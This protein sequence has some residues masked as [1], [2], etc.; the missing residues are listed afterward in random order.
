[1]ALNEDSSIEAGL[2]GIRRP[3]NQASHVPGDFYISDEVYELEKEKIFMRD[4]MLVARKEEV[5]TPGDF[6]TFRLLGEPVVATR[7]KDGGL[8][9]CAN[10]CA[11]RGVEVATGSGNAAEFSCPYHGWLYDL[12]G[13]LIGAPYMNE[14]EQPVD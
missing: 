8:N 1:M 3:V 13:K 6:M 7:D 2:A 10:V 11:H 4:W 12:T 5:A 9:A 14:A